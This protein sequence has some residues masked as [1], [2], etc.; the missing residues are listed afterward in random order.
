[1]V[2]SSLKPS[3]LLI[4]LDPPGL[5]PGTPALGSGT[6]QTRPLAQEVS[7][8]LC[9]CCCHEGA[10]AACVTCSWKPSLTAHKSTPPCST[11]P[12]PRSLPRYICAHCHG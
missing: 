4:S 1:M 2:S 8:V 10:C 12:R 7:V 3:P 9:A 11:C 6:S 5:D